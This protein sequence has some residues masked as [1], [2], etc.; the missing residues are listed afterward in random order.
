[1][2]ESNLVQNKSLLNRL[3]KTWL[4]KDFKD[5]VIDNSGGNRK[6]ANA[7]FLEKGEIAVVDQG[8]LR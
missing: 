5:V 6:L 3:P 1:M 2:K 7:D 4:I 8:K